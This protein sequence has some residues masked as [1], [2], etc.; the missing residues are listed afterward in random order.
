MKGG[1]NWNRTTVH[2]INATRIRVGSVPS[3]Q[4]CG[5]LLPDPSLPSHGCTPWWPHLQWCSSPQ[6]PCGAPS[7]SCSC[8]PACNPINQNAF[9]FWTMLHKKWQWWLCMQVASCYYLGLSRAQCSTVF[10]SL[11]LPLHWR[12]TVLW[13]GVNHCRRALKWGVLHHYCC[14]CICICR[15]CFAM[16]LAVEQEAWE[17]WRVARHLEEER[18]VRWEVRHWRRRYLCLPATILSILWFGLFGG[19]GGEEIGTAGSGEQGWLLLIG[20]AA[21]GG[22]YKR[23][24]DSEKDGMGWERGMHDKSKSLIS[25]DG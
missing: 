14:C 10:C 24:E 22:L 3:L 6:S 1:R 20:A 15:G 11:P 9:F 5:C 23:W 21:H 13:G 4:G 17:V 2:T 12:C 7:P 16:V 25:I 8:S 19:G 18:V